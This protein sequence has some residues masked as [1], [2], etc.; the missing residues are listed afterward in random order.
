[1]AHEADLVKIGMEGFALIDSCFGKRGGK[2]YAPKKSRAH[3]NPDP[4]IQSNIAATRRQPINH[5]IYH[6]QESHV[7]HAWKVS[8][9]ETVATDYET[10][11]THDGAV[12]MDFS[13][14]KPMRM[15]F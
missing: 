2:R 13:S 1:M 4:T 9:E 5:Y 15:A 8:A 10:A 3:Q 12:F 7:Y 11:R 6:P 14:G